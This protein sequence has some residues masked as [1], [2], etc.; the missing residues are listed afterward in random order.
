M[1]QDGEYSYI[2]NDK[3]HAVGNFVLLVCWDGVV[4]EDGDVIGFMS[5]AKPK[6]NHNTDE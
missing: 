6:N 5:R 2:K 1:E 3:L 4:E